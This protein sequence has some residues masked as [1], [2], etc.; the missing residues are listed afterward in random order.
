MHFKNKYQTN[1]FANIFRAI[2]CQNLTLLLTDF[3]LMTVLNVSKV[4]G[5]FQKHVW[6]LK[7]EGP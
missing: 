1:T 4:K 6:A 2:L 3:V 7:F 5:V